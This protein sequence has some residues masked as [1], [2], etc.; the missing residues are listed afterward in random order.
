MSTFFVFLLLLMFI[1]AC[2]FNLKKTSLMIG[3]IVILSYFFI[4]NGVIPAY[5]LH[6]LQSAYNLST[7]IHWKQKNTIILLGAGTSKDPK[8]NKIRPSLFAFSRIIQTVLLYHKCKKANT[9]C[10]ILIS[11]G[12]PLN[13]GNTEAT[14]Y[15]E[16]LLSLGINAKDIQ[17]ET[18]SNNTYQNA[19]FSS[20]LLKKQDS[21][22]LLL[23]NSA[24]TLKR[25]LLYFSFFNIYP[26]PIA[27]DFIT[28][29]F[30][31]YPIGYNFAM[32]DFVIH[33]YV[34]IFRFYLYDFFRNRISLY[35]TH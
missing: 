28:I 19:K 18:Q 8:S 21:S 29:P 7:P 6:N 27:S 26:T 17:L 34:G 15:Q 22:Q 31:R 3:S 24:F 25:S 9:I 35:A 30:T 2:L 32:N 10:T 33:E 12:D 4:G 5:L 14:I 23:V 16:A 1:L 11:G 13:N 20:F